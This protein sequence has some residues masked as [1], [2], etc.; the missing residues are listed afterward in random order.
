MGDEEFEVGEGRGGRR[1]HNRAR[2]QAARMLPPDVIS[3][4][5]RPESIH[6][7]INRVSLAISPTGLS[8]VGQL[9]EGGHLGRKG[10]AV[11]AG[12]LAKT[13]A[14]L[15]AARGRRGLGRGGARHSAVE[16]PR[17]GRIWKDLGHV[18]ALA[19]KSLKLARAGVAPEGLDVR[20]AREP[21][22]QASA[23]LRRREREEAGD[24]LAMLAGSHG[25]LRRSWDASRRSRTGI[26]TVTVV[27]RMDEA[28]M[29]GAR[30]G[31]DDVRRRGERRRLEALRERVADRLANPKGRDAFAPI[32]SRR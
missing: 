13:Q 17:Y 31:E 11:E 25:V 22:T 16:H 7:D 6:E 20:R 30:R 21:L 10:G 2:D 24:R 9:G 32:A 26:P 3:H 5:G 23:K 28:D 12:R 18:E 8:E 29:G 27:V 1:A 14:K 19:L 15:L 4:K